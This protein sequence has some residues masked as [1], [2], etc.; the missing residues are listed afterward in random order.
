MNTY[1]QRNLLKGS[2]FV[3]NDKIKL[4]LKRTSLLINQS[5]SNKN[6][7]NFKQ[8]YKILFLSKTFYFKNY[9]LLLNLV[10]NFRATLKISYHFILTHIRFL[11]QTSYTDITKMFY[12]TI[13]VTKS[14]LRFRNV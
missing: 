13:R 12:Y 11:K 6:N 5:I 1:E 3:L 7:I 2:Y 8:V 4:R 9:V 10:P 14:N